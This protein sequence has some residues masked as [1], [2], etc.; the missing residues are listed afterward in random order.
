MLPRAFQVRP[1]L[2]LGSRAHAAP[3]QCSI[4]V[5]RPAEPATQTLQDDSTATPLRPEDA[6]WTGGCPGRWLV[7]AAAGPEPASAAPGLAS[8]APGLASSPARANAAAIP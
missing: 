1:G 5:R 4:R 8:A 3:F 2:G 7:Q 6:L